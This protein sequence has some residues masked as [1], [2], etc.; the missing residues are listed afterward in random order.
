MAA[1]G[2]TKSELVIEARKVRPSVDGCTSTSVTV[3][4]IWHTSCDFD[5]ENGVTIGCWRELRANNYVT[6]DD[7]NGSQPAIRFTADQKWL[8]N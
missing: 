3:A 8:L 7:L 6:F 2:V 1:Y 4:E 5:Y